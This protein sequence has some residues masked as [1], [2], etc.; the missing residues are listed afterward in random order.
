[1]PTARPWAA[2]PVLPATQDIATWRFL[3]SFGRRSWWR[4]LCLRKVRRAGRD[5]LTAA[6]AMGSPNTTT[7]TYDS[8]N[9]PASQALPTGATGYLAYANGQ[10]MGGQIC[11]SSD[12]GHPR[13]PWPPTGWPPLAPAWACQHCWEPSLGQPHP[14]RPR[15]AQL[16]RRHLPWWPPAATDRPA[17]SDPGEPQPSRPARQPRRASP[18]RRSR[19]LRRRG[20]RCSPAP[21]GPT[22]PQLRQQLPL[23]FDSCSYAM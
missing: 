14:G 15:W 12:S 20:R 7:F 11:A 6:D 2:K 10:A 4:P 23:R 3:Y 19:R 9:N 17:C 13:V 1:M 8:L 21:T 16:V 22:S 18:P 5:V